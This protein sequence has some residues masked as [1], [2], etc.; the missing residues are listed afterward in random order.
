VR[1]GISTA[2]GFSQ[3]L[4]SHRGEIFGDYPTVDYHER[5]SYAP[6]PTG[7]CSKGSAALA[8]LLCVLLGLSGFFGLAPLSRSALLRPIVRMRLF[9]VVAARATEEEQNFLRVFAS[10]SFAYSGLLPTSIRITFGFGGSTGADPSDNPTV[11]CADFNTFSRAR[12]A[13]RV[14]VEAA[15]STLIQIPDWNA[16]DES[17]KQTVQDL[18]VGSL[19]SGFIIRWPQGLSQPL[20]SRT[21]AIPIWKN[22]ISE[23]LNFCHLCK[24]S[25]TFWRGNG[26]SAAVIRLSTSDVSNQ[27]R[28]DSAII[29]SLA[30]VSSWSEIL[31]SW[32]DEKK[33]PPSA[34]NSPATPMITINS[35]RLYQILCLQVRLGSVLLSPISPITRINPKKNN[36][37]FDQSRMSPVAAL[38]NDP[39]NPSA[40]IDPLGV[41][42][43]LMIAIQGIVLA[44][45]L[46]GRRK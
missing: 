43:A 19:G 42:V 38:D 25:A 44:W 1:S 14:L 21:I 18:L 23:S 41:A 11:K 32:R 33:I 27:Y 28:G 5:W 12:A 3:P 4:A 40:P 13:S 2:N 39:N 22:P 24:Q 9:M 37:A 10:H 46:I 36:V 26:L 20:S 35:N 34:I 7:R 8:L 17:S 16:F 30:W 29:R 15:E 6:T 31:C 45:F